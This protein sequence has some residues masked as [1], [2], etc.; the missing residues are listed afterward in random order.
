[1]R[2][3]EQIKNL[4]K[5]TGMKQ[6]ILAEKLGIE[7][8]NYSNIENGK[9]ITGKIQNIVS[10]SEKIL[11]PLLENKIFDTQTKLDVLLSIQDQFEL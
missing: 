7:Q 2:T 8:S 1:M 11:L 5:A 9:L 4:R 10:E 6:Y 3:I